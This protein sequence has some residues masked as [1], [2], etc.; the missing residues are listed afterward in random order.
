YFEIP[1]NMPL[2]ET[3]TTKVRVGD[4]GYWPPGSALA[5]FFGPTPLSR[6]SDPVPASDVNLVGRLTEDTAPLKK[7]KGTVKIRIEKV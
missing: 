2:D 4:I 6:G 3:A 5:I 7:L 1:V